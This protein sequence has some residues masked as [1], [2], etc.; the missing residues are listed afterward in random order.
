MQKKTDN[1]FDLIVITGPT[2]TGKTRLAAEL[3][4]ELD[5]EVIGADSRQVYKNMDIGTGKD[6][7]DYLVNGKII[8]V[9]IVD[10]VEPGYEFNVFEFQEQFLSA[11]D[12]ITKRNKQAIM[13]GGTGL[14]IE[15]ALARYR[16]LKVPQN[17]ALRNKLGELAHQQLVDKLASMKPLHNTTDTTSRDRLVRA[18]EIET[19]HQEN[20]D[21]Q[22]PMPI[23]NHIIFAINFPREVIRERITYRLRQRLETGM[24]EEIQQLLN[25]GIKPEQLIFY[26]LEYKYLTLYVTGKITYDEM[27]RK[28]NT[29]IHQ[30]AKRQMTWFRRMEKNGFVINWID[31]M[32][33]NQTKIDIIKEKLCMQN[34]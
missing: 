3:A 10:R 20:P 25:D 15:A 7:A 17:K 16:M 8:P 13:C 19:H 23:F 18:I 14:Y 29:A 33:D 9:H 30:F 11:F 4:F 31:G 6:M 28:L 34:T 1:P 5:G 12:D 24:I 22:N 27:F 21:V 32:Q 2:A 26:G